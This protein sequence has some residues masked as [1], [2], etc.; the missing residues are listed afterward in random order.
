MSSWTSTAGCRR[1]RSSG[2]QMPVSVSHAN[3]SA[4]L[5]ASGQLG[6]P[7]LE[8]YTFAGELALDGSIRPVPG[9]LAMAERTQRWGMRGIV[10][11][12]A[13]VPVAGLVEGIEVISLD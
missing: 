12:E 10:V 4:L 5:S 8:R 9:V 6:G 3:A 11:A 13:D 1:S 2:S 7:T